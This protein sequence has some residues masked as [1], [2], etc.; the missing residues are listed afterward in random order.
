MATGFGFDRDAVLQAVRQL[1]DVRSGLE[2]ARQQTGQLP[3]TGSYDIDLALDE[4]T[5]AAIEH[6]TDLLAAV[7]AVADRLDGVVTGHAQLDSALANE[8]PTNQHAKGK[9]DE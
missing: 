2:S 7:A 6:Q 3:K 1:T 8:L 4:F 9:R 5:E